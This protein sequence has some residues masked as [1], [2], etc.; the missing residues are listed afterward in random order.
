MSDL[1]QEAREE[2]II[3]DGERVDAGTTEWVQRKV[4]KYIDKATLAERKRIK[5]T[6]EDKE[7]LYRDDYHND[8]ASDIKGELLQAI[9][10]DV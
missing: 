10:E 9:E 5:K 2:I 7:F 1:K 8:I 6:I 3:M 4:R